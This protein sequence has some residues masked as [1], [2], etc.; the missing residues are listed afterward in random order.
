LHAFIEARRLVTK[1]REFIST[2]LFGC[3]IRGITCC[4]LVM[5][6]SVINAPLPLFF[7]LVLW[8]QIGSDGIASQQAVP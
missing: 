8:F 3:L 2:F 4:I 1:A 6:I 7:N 5:T